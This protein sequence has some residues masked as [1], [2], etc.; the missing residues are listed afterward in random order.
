MCKY[1]KSFVYDC[2]EKISQE[3]ETPVVLRIIEVNDKAENIS[4]ELSVYFH[5]ATFN[6]LFLCKRARPDLQ[7][8]IYFFMTIDKAS[9][10]YA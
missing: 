1:E 4:E 3:T 2:A 8:V 10:I 9:Y 6:I 7:K 5:N